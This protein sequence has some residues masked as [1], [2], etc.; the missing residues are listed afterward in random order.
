MSIEPLEAAAARTGGTL[1][2]FVEDL[3]PVPHVAKRLEGEGEGTVR[4]VCLLP[5]RSQE[6]EIELQG[7]YPVTAAIAGAIKAVPGVVHIENVQR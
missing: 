7:R 2:I 5:D 6:V 1:R 4:F 3:D